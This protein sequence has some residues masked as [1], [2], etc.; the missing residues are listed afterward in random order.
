[1]SRALF[2][3]ANQT[4]RE[5]VKGYIDS[6]P[7]GYRVI[8]NEPKRSTAQN[9]RMWAML[10][11]IAAQLNW[12]GVKLTP[13]DWKLIFLDGLKREM[14]VVPNLDGTGFVNLGRRSSDLSVREMTDL[15]ELIFSFGANHGVT[16]QA[17]R[18]NE[19]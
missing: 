15:I 4:V 12:H 16:F 10:T 8:L 3:L 5:R 14:R 7:E 13:D 18:K 6:A 11:K 17:D 2:I 1:M 9:D 19:N